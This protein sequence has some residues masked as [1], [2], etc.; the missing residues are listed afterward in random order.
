MKIKEIVIFYKNK[1]N[2]K[3]FFKLVAITFIVNFLD[4]LS[5]SL[6]IPIIEVFQND[7]DSS[8]GAVIFLS[9]IVVSLNLE[10]T[11]VVFLT[12][13][14]I[15]F[16]VKALFSFLLRYLSVHQA[17]LLQHELR[18]VLINGYAFSD[19]DFINNHRQ[20]VLLGTIGDHVNKV[21]NVYF[22][23]SQI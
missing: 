2:K 15:V 12:I 19:I 23:F 9:D 21:S 10:P 18:M 14:S 17:S 13:I 16:V 22:L 6:F 4:V 20:G 7:T 1:I 8:S 11:L 5:L 3:S